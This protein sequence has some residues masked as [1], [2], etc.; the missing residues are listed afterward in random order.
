[1]N[2]TARNIQTC[3]PFWNSFSLQS[4]FIHIS[5]SFLFIFHFLSICKQKPVY[6]VHIDKFRQRMLYFFLNT[7]SNEVFIL[8][9]SL[10]TDSDIVENWV[11]PESLFRM[12]HTW[13]GS[14]LGHNLTNGLSVDV[15]S[16]VVFTTYQANA[17]I[18]PAYQM[19]IVGDV[20]NLPFVI[21]QQLAVF[22]LSRK[23]LRPN[24]DHERQEREAVYK[25]ILGSECLWPEIR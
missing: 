1:M 7:A 19:E 5:I 24:F 21:R 9:Q 10:E 17:N 6:Q 15:N 11:I 22:Q 16:D 23:E 3:Y 20:A 4:T 2:L 18:Q 25:Y 14:K 12:Q 8:G 13:L